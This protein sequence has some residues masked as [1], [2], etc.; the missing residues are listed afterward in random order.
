MTTTQTF[1]DSLGWRTRLSCIRGQLETFKSLVQEYICQGEEC[2][3][4]NCMY[5]ASEH[6]HLNI[7]QFLVETIKC[8]IED[9][10]IFI[11]I[12]CL[13]GHLHIIKYFIENGAIIDDIDDCL[14]L[15]CDCGNLD[16]VKYFVAIG[17]NIHASHN[18]CMQFASVRNRLEVARY[19]I[20]IGSPINEYVSDNIKKYVEIY[21]RNDEKRIIRAQKKIYFWWIPI[22]YSL[23]HPSG[24]GIRMREKNLEAFRDMMNE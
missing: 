17:G 23:E 8:C 15:A 18:M 24:C 13:G 6:G 7:L 16:I 12:A 10:D 14:Q 9:S 19:L 1:D 20:S 21:N 22:C 11:R 4:Y 3:E 5:L 2:D